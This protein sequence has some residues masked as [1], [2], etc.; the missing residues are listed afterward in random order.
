MTVK[1]RLMLE[2]DDQPSTTTA[3]E[4]LTPRVPRIVA[5]EPDDKPNII[6][7]WLKRVVPARRKKRKQLVPVPCDTMARTALIMEIPRKVSQELAHALYGM[8]PN[9]CEDLEYVVRPPRVVKK[10]EGVRTV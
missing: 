4:V 8:D 6:S 7:K 2:I 3:D 5:I 10:Q 1:F 9:A